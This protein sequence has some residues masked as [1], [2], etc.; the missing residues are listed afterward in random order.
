VAGLIKASAIPN[1]LRP[2]VA[3]MMRLSGRRSLAFT[4]AAV[5]SAQGAALERLLANLAAYRAAYARAMD[6]SGADVVLSPP[7]ALAALRHGASEQLHVANAAAYA[8]LYNVLGLPAGVVPVATV[9][10]GEESDRPASRD[11]VERAAAESERGSAGL[12]VGVQVAARVW[13]ED[14]V[15]AAMA[16]IERAVRTRSGVVSAGS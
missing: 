11:P 14:L 3:A 7:H 6:V 2:V 10:A 5:R 1:V 8:V 15:L 9:G 13:R 16:A 4:I 12:P